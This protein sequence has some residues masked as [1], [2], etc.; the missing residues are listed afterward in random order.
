MSFVA[1]EEVWRGTPLF[2][3][4]D[5]WVPTLEALSVVAPELGPEAQGTSVS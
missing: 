5:A 1:V 4:R 3:M 2:P